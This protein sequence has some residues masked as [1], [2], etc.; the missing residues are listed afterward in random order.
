VFSADTAKAVPVWQTVSTIRESLIV[1]ANTYSAMQG[2]Q[3]RNS[4]KQIS[5]IAHRSADAS[6]AR[7]ADSQHPTKC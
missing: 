3:F 1:F 4:K 2:A 6:G 5:E 7:N